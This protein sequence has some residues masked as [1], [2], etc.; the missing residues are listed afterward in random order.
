[1]KTAACLLALAAALAAAQ[2]KLDPATAQKINAALSTDP[3]LRAMA[4][5]LGRAK[6]LRALGEAVYFGEISADDADTFSVGATLGAVMMSVFGPQFLFIYIALIYFTL[7]GFCLARIL[8]KK[9]RIPEQKTPFTPAPS[10]RMGATS[11]RISVTKAISGDIRTLPC[12]RRRCSLPPCPR[13]CPPNR[14]CWR[15]PM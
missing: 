3:V 12:G 2:P 6:N 8:G 15:R 11:A 14:R 4:E 10:E 7:G 5:E 1:M 13:P 9:G